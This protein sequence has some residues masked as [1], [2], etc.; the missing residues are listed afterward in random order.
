[1]TDLAVFT[2]GGPGGFHF[3]TARPRR[4]PGQ[5]GAAGDGETSPIT[6]LLPLIIL[7]AFALIS[8]L[9]T[10]FFD[11]TP[12]PQYSFLSSQKFDASRNTWQRGIQYY[13]N[14][15]EFEKSK[16]WQSVPEEKRNRPDAAMYSP[17]LRG[18]ER[19]IEN[20]YINDLRSQVSPLFTL[21]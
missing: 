14:R 3:Q 19:G 5:A 4:R 8:F 15:D 18:F 13:V 12:D 9:P 11:N 2:F 7:A 21:A 6:A 1:M 10:L 17:T 20:Y 16:I